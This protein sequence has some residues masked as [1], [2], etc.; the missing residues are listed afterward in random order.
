[1]KMMNQ[2]KKY[3]PKGSL[4]EYARYGVGGS[5]LAASVAVHAA[6]PESVKTSIEGSKTDGLEV[7]WIVV[8]VVAAIFVIGIVKRLIK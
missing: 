5:L 4:K 1:M 2:I 8:G 7:G 6:V 3:A